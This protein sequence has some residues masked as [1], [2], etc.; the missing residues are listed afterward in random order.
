MRF[1][2]RTDVHQSDRGPCTRVD[3][4][5]QTVEDKLV[6]VG[7]VAAKVGAAAVLDGGDFFH[8]PIPSRSSHAL[9]TRTAALHREHY[10]CPVLSNVGN[11][12]VRFGD[13]RYLKESPLAVLFSTNTFRP[14]HKDDG[15]IVGDSEFSVRIAGVPYNRHGFDRDRLRSLGRKGA[16]HLVVLLHVAASPRGGNLGKEEIVSYK[17]IVELCPEASVFLIGHWHKD[18]GVSKVGDAWVVNCGSLTRGSIAEDDLLRTPKIA[19]LEMLPEEVRVEILPLRVAAPE[20]VFDL[21]RRAGD[22]E[23]AES[24]DRATRVAHL[25]SSLQGPRGPTRDLED[26][27]R[28]IPDLRP[29]V[30]ARILDAL[31]RGA[32]LRQGAR[33]G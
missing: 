30:R 29:E 23:R 25:F 27:V 16:A 11:H 28:D 9:V 13:L 15:V 2:W 12:D 3:D 14:C 6:Q 24:Q 17:E 5:T 26:E 21:R 4:W 20:T 32:D 18:Q 33:S 31:Q 7:Q 22:R 10:P 1:V 19:V 8:N